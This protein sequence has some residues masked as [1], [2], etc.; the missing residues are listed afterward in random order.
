MARE[1]LP[2]VGAGLALALLSW[3]G[4][5]FFPLLIYA[6]L[7]FGALS[8]F[9]VFFFRDPGRTPPEGD[10]LILSA[11]DGKVV[12]IANIEHDEHLECAAIQVS[13]F[14]SPF[15]VHVNRNP[16]SGVIDFVKWHRGHFH[17]AFVAAAS[18]EN[19]QSIIAIRHGETRI[20]VKQIV[21][22]LARRIVC[23]LNAGDTVNK[24]EKFGLIRF[25]SRVDLILPADTELRV[26]V[27]DR[28]RAGET[29]IGAIDDVQ[30]NAS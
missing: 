20:L 30:G 22:I 9:M 3:L 7:L 19:E 27:G 17:A 4:A 24:G 18:T 26:K 10:N 2:F 6:V 16:L 12:S 21:G 28:V 5:Q 11:A 23:Y 25:G 14:L 1:G 15:D 29:I 13:T 8:L